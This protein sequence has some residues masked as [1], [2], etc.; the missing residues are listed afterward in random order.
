MLFGDI[1][2]DEKVTLRGLSPEVLLDFLLPG[3]T[4]NITLDIG[5]G[6]QQLSAKLDTIS[7]R[8]DDLEMDMI[9]RGGC[10]YEGYSW[11]PQMKRLNAEI[12]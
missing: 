2:G 4:P 12:S 3:E 8:P 6:V 1:K 5:L 10:V 7:I 9:W 11:L